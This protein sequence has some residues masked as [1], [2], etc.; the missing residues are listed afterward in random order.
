MRPAF[1]HQGPSTNC[2]IGGKE[3]GWTSCTA[4]AMAMLIDAATDGRVRP[5]GCAVR[6]L[7]RPAD[8]VKG[9]TLGQV[10]AVAAAAFGVPIALRTGPNIISVAG[11]VR[12]IR[13][14][15]GFVL[16]GNNL[17]WGMGDVNHAVYVHEV[18]GGSDAA[19]AEGLLYDP[20]RRHERWM[21]WPRL[22]AFGA[23]LRMDSGRPLGPGVLYAGFAPRDQAVALPVA[24][25][26]APAADR[27]LAPPRV[28]LRFRARRLRK[29]DRTVAHPPRGR[30]VN[31]RSNPKSLVRATVVDTLARGEVFVAFQ[32]TRGAVPPGAASSMWYGNRDGTQWV[33]VSGLRSIDPLPRPRGAGGLGIAPPVPP[34]DPTD[35]ELEPV[36]VPAALDPAGA[37]DE[38]PAPVDALEEAPGR[39]DLDPDI[40]NDPIDVAGGAAMPV[41]ASDPDPAPDD[42][43]FAGRPLTDDEIDALAADAD[44]P[45]G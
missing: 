11:A 33:H 19:P 18:R 29:P 14:G 27:V 41:A 9:L 20:Q 16:Q 3:L 22:L 12:R 23:A 31:V 34:D 36:D 28:T 5:K 38:G 40:A 17:A 25:P 21:A 26:A 1:Q 13:A 10:A 32:R 15:R 45:G 44:D 7:I 4:Y 37:A 24:A 8:T 39:D 35:P 2:I 6:R 43:A 42:A 30:Q